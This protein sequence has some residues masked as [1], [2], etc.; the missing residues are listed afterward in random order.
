MLEQNESVAAVEKEPTLGY[1][2]IDL[3][4]KI[5]SHQPYIG[6]NA[7][8]EQPISDATRAAEIATSNRVRALVNGLNAYS[9][10]AYLTVALPCRDDPETMEKWVTNAK[11]Y[12]DQ[13]L[14]VSTL[15]ANV[16][17]KRDIFPQRTREE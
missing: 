3:V 2:F 1:F 16:A 6:Q 12:A 11:I 9:A 10:C 4:D 7:I 14:R 13:L 17:D 8:K 15:V 5:P